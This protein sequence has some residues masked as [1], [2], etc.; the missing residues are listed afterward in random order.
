MAIANCNQ[1]LD[2]CKQ[3]VS[4]LHTMKYALNSY[5][6]VVTRR[7]FVDKMSGKSTDYIIDSNTI[8][9]DQPDNMLLA[10]Y[11]MVVG[12][13]VLHMTAEDS[14]RTQRLIG[15]ILKYGM[16]LLLCY[17]SCFCCRNRYFDRRWRQLAVAHDFT[18]TNR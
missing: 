14:T 4:A 7:V 15:D 5:E 16:L 3:L 17:I 1:S 13:M 12:T 9:T 11:Q 2:L 6:R 18:S 8:E 10:Y